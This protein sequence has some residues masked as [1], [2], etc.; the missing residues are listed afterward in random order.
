MPAPQPLARDFYERPPVT[1]ARELLGKVLVHGGVS[2]AITEVEAYL[3]EGDPAAHSAAG[4]TPR[5][6]V[7]FGPGGFAYV[8]LIYGIHDCFNIACDVNGT[9][10]CVLIRALDFVT[11]P[12][13][14]TKAM[15][16][17]RRHSGL[18]LTREPLFVV[19]GP[20][21]ARLEVTPRIGIS[22]A[23]DLPLRF[24]AAGA[25]GPRIRR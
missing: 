4:P 5:N 24:V 21:P 18:T 1:V 8:Y 19:P 17:T 2:G 13:R 16:I 12:G 25:P 11:G 14:L 23:V 9:P 15:G 10:G 6:R 22:K 20:P 7:L 3:A